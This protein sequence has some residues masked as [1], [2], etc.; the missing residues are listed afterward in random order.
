MRIFA[1]LGIAGALIASVAACTVKGQQS[2]LVI[3]AALKINASDA[4]TVTTCSCPAPA[5]SGSISTGAVNGALVGYDG[6]EPCLQIENRL[7]AN[8][9][10]G[11]RL[12]SNDFQAEEEHLT[13]EQVTGTPVALPG[14]TILPATVYIPT[15]SVVTAGVPLV[16]TS[17]GRALPAGATA[18]V[19]VYLK[20]HLLDNSS[21]RTSE[22]EFLVYGCGGSC[23][24]ACMTSPF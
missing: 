16:P 12:N 19:H 23:P 6:Y 18:R 7:P 10:T 13:F 20:G 14:E 8:G 1:I 2:N 22:F 17:V 9:V 15:G 3:S 21:V 4:G 5:T 11:I 24:Q